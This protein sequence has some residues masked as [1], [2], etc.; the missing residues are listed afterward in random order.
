MGHGSPSFYYDGAGRSRE[1]LVSQ[2]NPMQVSSKQKIRSF[3]ISKTKECY[4]DRRTFLGTGAAGSALTGLHPQVFAADAGTFH[5]AA[6]DIPLA[7]RYD[8]IVCGGGSAGVAAA[9]ASARNGA[10]TL[11]LET[12]GCLGGM[13]T[14]GL[15]SYIMDTE[16][17]YGLIHEITGRLAELDAGYPGVDGKVSVFTF[18]VERMKLVME[19]LCAESGVDL[20]YHARAVAVGKGSGNRI[21]HVVTESKSGRQAWQAGVVVDATGDGD[22]AALSG[23][24]FDWGR[25]EDGVAQPF[26]MMI[27][28]TGIHASQVKDFTLVSED[29]D[30]CKKNLLA[31]MKRAGLDPSY[32]RPTLFRIYDDLFILAATHSYGYKSI[33]TADVTQSTLEKRQEVHQFVDALRSLGGPWK[34]LKLVATP[35]QIGTREGRRIHG[36]YTVSREDTLNGNTQPDS[37]CRVNFNVDIHAPSEKD[38]KGYTYMHTKP[39]DIPLRALIAKDVSGLML[40]GR[41]IS[42]DFYAHAS[43]RV[44]GNTIPMGQAAGATAA[45]AAKSGRRPQ[46]VPF[47]EVKKSLAL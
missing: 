21:T 7:G 4:M 45:L 40:A 27:M 42:G 24:G 33:D 1:G 44:C 19:R 32:T 8:V 43:Y 6:R 13:L 46:D 17:K 12:Q 10:K 29:N 22:V 28:L 18:D 25:P 30:T 31:E 11:L 37:I 35:N 5:E 3:G 16:D 15:L 26:S 9:V 36:I 14:A 41:C 20:L 2:N 38:G 34:G 23:C 39:Y 47:G